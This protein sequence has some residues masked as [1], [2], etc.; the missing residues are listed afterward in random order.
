MP[1]TGLLLLAMVL[2]ASPASTAQPVATA[3]TP[4]PAAYASITEAAP[5]QNFQLAPAPP[6]ANEFELPADDVCYKIRAYIFKRD[7]DHAPQ[8]VRS[9]TCG[10]GRPHAKS[11]EEPQ[12][13]LIPA[14]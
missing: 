4:D 6:P 9:T 12:G 11:V 5:P 7:D 10:P 13:K 1:L 3:G 8:Y 2:P 14:N